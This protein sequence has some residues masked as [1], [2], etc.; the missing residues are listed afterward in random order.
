MRSIS[1]YSEFIQAMPIRIIPFDLGRSLSS[2]DIQKLAQYINSNYQMKDVSPRKNAILKDCVFVYDINELTVAHVY[3]NGIAVIVINEPP[4]DLSSCFQSFSI[5]YGENRKQAHSSLFR[6]EHPCSPDISRTINDMRKIVKANGKGSNIRRSASTDFENGGMS[7]VMTLSMFDVSCETSGY[8]A[9]PSWLKCNISALLDP[10]LVYLEDSSKYETA[11]E[12]GFNLEKLLNEA[13]LEEPPRDYER[14]RHINTYMSWAAVIVIGRLQNSDKEEYTALEVQL[15]CDWF[16]VY[17][18]EKSI[19]S[20]EKPTKQEMINYQRQNYE[21][22]LLENRLYDF[23]DSSIPARILDIQKGLVATSGLGDNI[24]HAQRKIRYI[25]ERE[26]LNSELRQKKLGQSTELLL[27]I[28]AF[29][30]IAPTVAEYGEV[31]FHHAGTLL[32][33]I[34]LILGLVLTLRKDR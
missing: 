23:D 19:T 17:C 30:E 28:I 12:T 14:H 3:R 34:I 25:L 16:Y 26:Q 10:S 6:W 33:G 15:Q 7:Y 2:A 20:E 31:L 27:F 29:I 1:L 9:Y 18:I 13:A 24:N 21:L 11:I 32:N 8:K 4:M 5:T 22:D